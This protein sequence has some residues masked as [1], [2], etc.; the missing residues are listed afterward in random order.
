[1]SKRLNNQWLLEWDS[2]DIKKTRGKSGFFVLWGCFP[3]LIC[4]YGWLFR[5]CK[6]FLCLPWWRRGDW[7][8]SIWLTVFVSLTRDEKSSVRA[9]PKKFRLKSIL[10]FLNLDPTTHKAILAMT[11]WKRKKPLQ[12]RLFI[13]HL[14]ITI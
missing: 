14:R 10:F 7:F 6:S 1:M 4:H 5:G 3:C 11:E 8:I 2:W 9:V 12:E 13:Y